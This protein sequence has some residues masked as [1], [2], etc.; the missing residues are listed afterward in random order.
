[1]TSRAMATAEQVDDDSE[2][3]RDDAETDGNHRVQHQSLGVLSCIRPGRQPVNEYVHAVVRNVDS[4]V[5]MRLVAIELRGLKRH[6]RCGRN[7]LRLSSV[8]TP[9]SSYRTS[10]FPQGHAKV[11]VAL[12][13]R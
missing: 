8:R 11:T 13:R 4:F 12:T 2:Q 6:I 10:P 5:A 3:D 1:M 7:T 9:P